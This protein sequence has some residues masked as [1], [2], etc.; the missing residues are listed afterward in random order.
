MTLCRRTFLGAAA[1]APWLSAP[2]RAEPG[3]ISIPAGDGQRL[4]IE[5]SPLRLALADGDGRAV[6][7]VAQR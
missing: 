2:T 1:A 5:R 3:A 7:A 6:V 4:R